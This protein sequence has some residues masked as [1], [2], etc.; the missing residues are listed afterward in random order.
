MK[1][2]TTEQM[3]KE[4]KEATSLYGIPAL[5]LMEN[6]ATE[7]ISIIDKEFGFNG[8]KVLVVC[9]GGNNGGDGL[10][11]ARKLFCTGI[12]VSIFKAFD[13]NGLKE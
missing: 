9:G 13:E 4:D 12:N 7:C 8:K 6:A 5:L 2:T 1:I 11:I 10:A 3:F